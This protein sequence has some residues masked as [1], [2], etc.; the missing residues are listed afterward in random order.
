LQ[1]TTSIS[2]ISLSDTHLSLVLPTRVTLASGRVKVEKFFFYFILS[3][4]LTGAP[5]RPKAPKAEPIETKLLLWTISQ[6][7]I[8]VELLSCKESHLQ[9]FFGEIFLQARFFD[10]PF[11]TSGLSCNLTTSHP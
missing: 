2:F 7:P 3:L 10:R 5:F 4:I 1:N 11:L 6:L 8:S 9:L